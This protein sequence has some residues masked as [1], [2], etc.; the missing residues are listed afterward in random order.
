MVGT[1]V[2]NA[3]WTAP[4]YAAVTVV[5]VDVETEFVEIVKVPE[6]ASEG[7]LTV[8]GTVI[9]A[10]F[11]ETRTLNPPAGAGP[12]RVMVP[13]AV[14]PPNTCD[15]VIDSEANRGSTVTDAL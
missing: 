1:T 9:A 7:T 13:E 3:A 6:V 5:A 11:P 15:G 4:A 8:V 12:F 10:E 2:S 14:P